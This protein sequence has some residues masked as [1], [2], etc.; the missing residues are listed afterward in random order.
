MD[1]HQ[2]AFKEEAVELLTE[3]ESSLLELEN[4]PEST[5]LI[6]KVFRAMHTI[7]GSGSMF[8]FDEI[9]EFTHNVET[10]LDRVRNGEMPVSTE[11]INLILAA[12]D[13]ILSMLGEDDAG[14]SVN[15]DQTKHIVDALLNLLTPGEDEVHGPEK[16]APCE[17]IIDPTTPTSPPSTSGP[18]TTYRIRFRPAPNIF[19]TG[20]NP[21][22]LL[23]EI[24]ELGKCA[25]IARTDAIPA[26]ENMDP[27][28]CY[29]GWDIILTTDR[30]INTV[31]DVFIFVEDTSDLKIEVI[32][33]E[34]ADDVPAGYKLVGD[35][36]VERGNISSDELKK[37]LAE[38]K[39]LGEK[40]IERGLVGKSDLESALME[41]KHVREQRRSSQ[42]NTAASSIRV[43]AEKLDGL[44]DLVG[45]LVTVQARLS[46]KASISL[47]PELVAIS[48]EVERLTGDLRDNTMSIRM[49]PIGTTFSK[50]LRLVRDLSRDLGKNITL[51]TTGGET[52]LDK[53]VI[54]RLNDPLVHIIR[55]CIDHAIES[56]DIR[57][58]VGKTGQ[59]TIHL[60]ATHSGANVLIRISDD[61]KGL[62]TESIKAKA[63]EK[64]LIQPDAELSDKEIF[65][66]IFTP[67]FSMAKSVTDV[68]GRGVGMD[69]VKRS[70]ESLG[71]TVDINSEKGKGTTI[72]L[73]IPLTLAIIDGLLVKIG[74]GSY[75]IPLAV[76]EECV[77]LPR[78]IADQAKVQNM[79][80]YRESPL[81]YLNLRDVFHETGIRPPIEKVVIAEV[82]DTKAGFGVDTVVG[83]IQTV[84]KSLGKVY[85]NVEG[86]SGATIL[87]DGTVALIIDIPKLV[88]AVAGEKEQLMSKAI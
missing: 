54:E 24:R 75:V 27:E 47:D 52:E 70:I 83:Q 85:K 10:V 57:K 77:E 49:L 1:Q 78:N 14:G 30:G 62:D 81:S 72:T 3:L 22:S 28:K 60:A 25:I 39:K 16:D 5:E 36:L 69:V 33:Q 82:L 71:G 23:D 87:G 45:E 42:V 50:F 55:N 29:T 73:K 41:Q 48:E 18:M 76:V 88:Q 35:I 56:P 37:V 13:Q 32:D 79:M 9:A 4:D 34:G 51:T 46:R 63:V 61:G 44:V 12:R 7:K 59:G 31:K 2:I 15:P 80:S 64:G 11:L 43:E 74:E 8:G 84:I 21:L 20:A 53:T 17:E 86:V 38:Q 19:M 58:T 6:G 26:L 40:L 68:S 66:L 65:T 67:G